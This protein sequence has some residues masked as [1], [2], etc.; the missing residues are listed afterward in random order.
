MANFY[1]LLESRWR[2]G[3]FISVGLDSDYAKLPECIKTSSITETIF[4]FNKTIIEATA[5]YCCVFKPNSAFYEG[6]GLEGLKALMETNRYI[7]E[8]YPE[9]PIILD[10]KR[11]DIGNTNSGYVKAAFDIYLAH[12]IT[13]HPYLGQEALKPFLENKEWGVLVL[14]HTSNPGAG[15]FQELK[16]GGQEI[17]KIVASQVSQV[18]NEN[19]NCGLVVGAT[20]PAQL[21]E[22][23]R[24][25]PDLPL[26]IP[27]IGA[28]GGDLA[29]TVNLGLNSRGNGII[30]NSSRNIIYASGDSD[31]GEAAKKEASKLDQAI[32][33]F[34]PEQFK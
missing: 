20:Y 22:V 27:G 11:A 19:Q 29:Q 14:C 3:H 4:N 6:Y 34:I 33:Q 21:A 28:Q 18:W 7:R 9:I 24:I 25:A 1:Q 8:H 15:E 17:Y 2:Q 30:I 10:A 26:L 13:V 23:R 5:E 12:A 32:F 16:S 31:F